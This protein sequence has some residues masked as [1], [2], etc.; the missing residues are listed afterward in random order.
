GTSYVWKSKLLR[1]KKRAY[2]SPAGKLAETR[3]LYTGSRPAGALW[4]LHPKTGRPH[5]LRVHL[6]QH[7]FPILGDVLYGA[8]Q[9]RDGG[10]IA[11]RAVRLSLRGCSGREVFGLPEDL[12]VPQR[13]GE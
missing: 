9:P 4:E 2:E 10:G 3:A 1:G 7:G 13:L 6:A 5:Q 8:K 12:S 11:L